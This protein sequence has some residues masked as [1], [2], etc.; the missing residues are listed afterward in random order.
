MNKISSP[1]F[2]TLPLYIT[3]SR[4]K[5]THETLIGG[6]KALFDGP[7]QRTV[8]T[9]QA[10]LY[11]TNGGYMF[12]HIIVRKCNIS[13][14]LLFIG[15]HTN[16]HAEYSYSTVTVTLTLTLILILHYSGV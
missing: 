3:L 14:Q 12:C 11:N 9:E 5:I 16:I 1:L 15:V 13:R 4:Q 8:N 7:G 2:T 6:P 10:P